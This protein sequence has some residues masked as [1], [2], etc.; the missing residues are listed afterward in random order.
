MSSENAGGNG[1]AFLFSR[2][3]QHAECVEWRAGQLQKL[4]SSFC[5]HCELAVEDQKIARHFV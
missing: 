5:F 1:D 4:V 2:A 3:E